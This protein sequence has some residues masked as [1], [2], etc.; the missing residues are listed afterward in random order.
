[1]RKV[2]EVSGLVL[3]ACALLLAGCSDDEVEGPPKL[4]EE[5]EDMPEG[6]EP[7]SMDEGS[8]GG[9]DLGQGSKADSETQGRP[10]IEASPDAEGS[11]EER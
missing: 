9:K 1:M 7:G 4:E 11:G 3:V 5:F 6:Q 8:F 10:S 2:G